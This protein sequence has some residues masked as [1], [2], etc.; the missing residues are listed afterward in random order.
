MESSNSFFQ[1]I[2][3]PTYFLHIKKI[4]FADNKVINCWALAYN[5]KLLTTVS[6]FAYQTQQNGN[7][8]SDAKAVH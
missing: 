6:N 7:G 3:T 8:V 4:S 1:L 5:Y 2:Y